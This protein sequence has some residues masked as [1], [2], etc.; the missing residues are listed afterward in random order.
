MFVG[1]PCPTCSAFSGCLRAEC[2]A[3]KLLQNPPLFWGEMPS[4]SD[5]RI[6]TGML[7]VTESV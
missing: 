1:H 4:E 2:K 6:G 7:F 3:E 5:F